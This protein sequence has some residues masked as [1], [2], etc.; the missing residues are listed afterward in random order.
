M[1]NTQY[2]GT[3]AGFQY[4]TSPSSTTYNQQYRLPVPLRDVRASAKLMQFVSESLDFTARQVLTISSGGYELV[5]TIRYADDQQQTIDFLRYGTMGVPMIYS[6]NITTGST[7]GVPPAGTSM[8][9]I[10]PNG[11]QLDTI[12]DRQRTDFEDL[13]VTCRFRR[14]DSQ[15][16]STM[17]Q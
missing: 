5:G 12:L 15:S 6:T 8:Y 17:F 11:P 14:T 3:N 16:F 13:E 2:L 7:A 1:P 4:T 9:L 10:E